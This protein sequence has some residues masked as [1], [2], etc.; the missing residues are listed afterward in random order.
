LKILNALLLSA[1]LLLGVGSAL[2]IGQ[3]HPYDNHDGYNNGH[4]NAEYQKG[5]QDGINSG[6]A[7][8]NDHKR[9]D[10]EN[11]PYYRN[12]HNEA[13]RTGFAKG[14]HEAYDHDRHDHDHDHDNH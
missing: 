4:N 2:A 11:H 14:Y 1:V 8:A 7:D 3:D 5:Y 12:S 9:A 13:Y 6:R 10:L